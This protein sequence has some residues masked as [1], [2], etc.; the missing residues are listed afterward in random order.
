MWYQ[1]AVEDLL[2]ISQ[3]QQICARSTKSLVQ[4][5][6]VYFSYAQNCCAG[7]LQSA[8]AGHDAVLDILG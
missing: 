2:Y 1:S 7:M 3:S 4:T 8:T 5:T 6:E